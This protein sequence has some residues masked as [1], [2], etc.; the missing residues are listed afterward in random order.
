MHGLLFIFAAHLSGAETPD[1]L[2]DWHGID[3]RVFYIK[4]R[5]G[6]IRPPGFVAHPAAGG[7]H[8]V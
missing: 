5:S 7:C 2:S 3:R 4:E 1:L 6:R 8:A